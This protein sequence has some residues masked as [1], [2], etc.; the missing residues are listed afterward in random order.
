MMLHNYCFRKNAE[1]TK[2][3]YLEI[4]INSDGLIDWEV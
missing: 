2:K 4:K 3:I 1:F